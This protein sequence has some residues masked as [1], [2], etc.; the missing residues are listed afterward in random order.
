[1]SVNEKMTLLA[2]AVRSKSGV[3]GKLSLDGMATAVNS[4]TVGIDTSDATAV[5]S[6]IATGKTAYVKGELVTGTGVETTYYKC[7]DS[8]LVSP[9]YAESLADWY[10]ISSNSGVGR[11]AFMLGNPGTYWDAH[12]IYT[13]GNYQPAQLKI[14]FTEKKKI[15][16]YRIKFYNNSYLSSPDAR[17][18]LYGVTSTS[19]LAL[20]DSFSGKDYI[21]DNEIRREFSSGTYSAYVLEFTDDLL[22]GS[23][24]WSVSE[25]ALYSAESNYWAGYEAYKDGDDYRFEI[26]VT[27]RLVFTGD[28]PPSPGKCYSADGTVEV[29]LSGSPWGSDTTATTEDI[30]KGKT[31][32]IGGER[33]TGTM[34]DSEITVED[35]IVTVTAGRVIEN[36]TATIPEMTI[37]NDGKNI[38][39]PVGYNKTEQTFTVDGS[40]FNTSDAT[41]TAADVPEGLVFYGADG[42]ETGTMPEAKITSGS[43]PGGTWGVAVSAGYV[44]E[45][46]GISTPLISISVDND[47]GSVTASAG[48]NTEEVTFHLA[49]SSG[50]SVSGATVSVGK[51]FI[52]KDTEATVQTGSVTV[53]EI[54]HKVIVTEGYV[55]E[56]QIAIETGAD[57]TLGMVNDDLDFQPVRF[58]GTD[59]VPEGIAI[60]VSAYYSWNNNAITLSDVPVI[61]GVQYDDIEFDLAPYA[62]AVN[63][64]VKFSSSDLPV[65]LYLDGSVIKG[66]PSAYGSFASSVTVSSKGVSDKVLNIQFAIEEATIP[67]DAVFYAPLS[68]D[69]SNAETGQELNVT[70]SVTYKIVDGIPCATFGG[71]C[72]ITSSD[73]QFP[74]GSNARTV[75]AWVR[76][77]STSSDVAILSY[78]RN[79]ASQRYT[80]A[81]SNNLL[82]IWGHS[83]ST[84]FDYTFE[85]TQWYHIVVTFI[86]DTE[87]LYVNG[88]LVDEGTHANMNTVLNELCIGACAGDHTDKLIGSVSAIRIY[89]RV[90]SAEEIAKLASEFTPEVS[91]DDNLIYYNKLESQTETDELGSELTYYGTANHSYSYDETLGRNVCKIMRG[92]ITTAYDRFTLPSTV[93]LSVWAKAVNSNGSRTWILNLFQQNGPRG[94]TLRLDKPGVWNNSNGSPELVLPSYDYDQWHHHALTF[95]GTT[96]KYYR[97]GVLILSG[98][99]SSSS[100]TGT[101]AAAVIGTNYSISDTSYDMEAYVSTARIYDR[102]LNED[103]IKKLASEITIAA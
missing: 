57:V 97:D 78:G 31:A 72:F 66:S 13:D 102:A 74:T 46:T 86:G 26:A 44:K 67:G 19:N 53:D 85:D 2:D 89:D 103:E 43:I 83:N 22:P 63:G 71:N 69:K 84:S 14:Q 82:C 28:T 3:T 73:T 1:M 81:L 18:N 47:N 15:D 42:R 90:L 79:A 94:Y 96:A 33:V 20:L 91:M 6:D 58:E 9:A 52:D 39:V 5:A 48:Y 11:Y 32:Y 93:T 12:A 62:S 4:I 88:A 21:G 65:G 37:T 25:F 23:G 64:K 76:K 75:S 40:G 68:E 80:I 99:G 51:G 45:P 41:A 8:S 56:Q 29:N 49:K 17:I 60:P 55:E 30:V 7:L 70:G 27:D 35:N 59:A 95:D 50:L 87:K 98:S 92:A 101:A 36:A 100:L 77:G 10:T 24:R 54:A 16:S 34:P 38:T 61:S